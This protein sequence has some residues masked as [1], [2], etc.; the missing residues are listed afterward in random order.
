MV[1][2]GAG[3]VTSLG[4]GWE[5]NA[6][7][8]RTGRRAF[9]PVTLFDVSRQR[10]KVAAQVELPVHLPATRLSERRAKQKDRAWQLLLH[11]TDEAWQQSKWKPE[12]G[13]PIVLGTTSGGMSLGEAYYRQ[14]IATPLA[15]RSQPSRVMHYQAQRQGLD[16]AEAFGF[17]GPVTIIAN[18]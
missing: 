15:R 11:A 9:S 3:I 6:E 4:F 5:S 12:P 8:F 2:T 16:L 14:A 18:A 10:V 17:T 7:G 1:V 13:L